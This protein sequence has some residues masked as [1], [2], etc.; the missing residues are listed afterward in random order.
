MTS[1]TR[2]ADWIR[3]TSLVSTVSV[4]HVDRCLP[5]PW[6]LNRE[7]IYISWVLCF[8]YLSII[9]VSCLYYKINLKHNKI[10]QYFFDRNGPEKY[11]NGVSLKIRKLIH[12]TRKWVRCFSRSSFQEI[13]TAFKRIKFKIK[14][15]INIM[16]YRL[17][18]LPFL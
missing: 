14:L 6:T 13:I 11:N 2:S 17:C 12:F 4:N 8:T 7:K 9:N 1:H 10:L 16:L 3:H 15:S 5:N 18:W